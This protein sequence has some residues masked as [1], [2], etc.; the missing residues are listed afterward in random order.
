MPF[1]PIEKVPRLPPSFFFLFSDIHINPGFTRRVIWS[2][3]H[4]FARRN[5]GTANCGLMC[6]RA[7][8]RTAYSKSTYLP[9]KGTRMDPNVCTAQYPVPQSESSPTT[10]TT[11]TLLLVMSFF[12]LILMLSV[13]HK[14]RQRFPS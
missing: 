6:L 7:T 5:F 3:F 9:K 1:C 12:L 2:R 13:H 14:Q 10:V 11:I 8:K 4:L